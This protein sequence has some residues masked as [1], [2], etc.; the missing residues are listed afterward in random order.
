MVSHLEL[1]ALLE[2]LVHA[3]GR[4]TGAG[5]AAIGVL[6]G[7]RTRLARFV[8]VGADDVT[9]DRLEP[10]P[11]GRG[12]LGV[13]HDAPRLVRIEDVREHPAFDGFPPGHPALTSFLTAPVL[14]D[15]EAWGMLYLADRAEGDFGPRE[16]ETAQRLAAWAGIAAGNAEAY[17]RSERDRLALE[18]AVQG[19]EAMVDIML[20]VGTEPD[21]AEVLAVI[22]RRGRSLAV[23]RAVVI[24]LREGDEIVVGALDGEV[25]TLAVGQRFSLRDSLAAKALARRGAVRAVSGDPVLERF[26]MVVGRGVLTAVTAVPLVHRDEVLGILEVVDDGDPPPELDAQR[27]RLIESFAASA[28]VAIAAA[29][30]ASDE[31][32][33]TALR[34]QEHERMRWARELHDDTLQELAALTMEL[35]TAR[36][37]I[38]HPEAR[39]RLEHAMQRATRQVEGLRALITELRPL[40]LDDLGLAAGIEELAARFTGATGIATSL[41]LDDVQQAPRLDPDVETA[42]YRITQEALTNV[43]R[44]SGATHAD[45]VVRQDGWIDLRVTD[46]G[47]GFSLGS[48]A[49]GFGLEGMRERAGLVG[50]SLEVLPGAGGTT[51]HARLPALLAAPDPTTEDQESV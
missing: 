33:R 24:G 12:L 13:A 36:R 19:L 5:Y 25:G 31:R 47:R 51:I 4:L 28:S 10:L 3:A 48:P 18:A 2:A 35:A 29:R 46:D 23:A 37:A 15:G 27:R 20:A 6:A 30:R 44:H 43:G 41:D 17:A 22:A 34:A 50:G 39:A 14:V 38:D 42:A 40:G 11:S 49:A 1:D 8:E 21:L 9:H 45:I 16:L 26:E 7:D 32:M